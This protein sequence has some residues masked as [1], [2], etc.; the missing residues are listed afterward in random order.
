MVRGA[1]VR[2][3][4]AQ[5]GRRTERIECERCGLAWNRLVAAGQRPKFCSDAC[6]QAAWRERVGAAELSRRRRAAEEARRQRQLIEGYQE[7]LAQL[8][9]L[10]PLSRWRALELLYE[11][12]GDTGSIRDS[13]ARLYKT[14]ALSWH[15][16]RGGD[17]Q[18]FQLLQEAYRVTV[19]TR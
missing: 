11:L 12:A 6:K 10:M 2:S 3:V 4:P 19:A 1:T 13:P 15:P 18:V 5:R 16:D 7:E 17:H 8:S 9:A 14:A